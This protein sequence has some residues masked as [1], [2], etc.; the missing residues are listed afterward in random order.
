GFS[1][2]VR[3]L[4]DLARIKPLLFGCS[5]RSAGLGFWR[6][7]ANDDAPPRALLV[8]LD[9]IGCWNGLLATRQAG[10]GKLPEASDERA[11]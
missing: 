8:T 5:D 11:A 1:V 9:E 7:D 2:D 10:S 6:Y 3:F 4:A